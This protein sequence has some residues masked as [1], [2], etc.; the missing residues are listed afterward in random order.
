M[1]KDTYSNIPSND[2]SKSSTS[3]DVEEVKI[4]L[5]NNEIGYRA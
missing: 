1:T 2:E 5:E 3:A 4:D